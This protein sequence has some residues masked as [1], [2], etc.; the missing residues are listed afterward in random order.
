MGA[1]GP[2]PDV[3]VSSSCAVHQLSIVKHKFMQ[4]GEFNPVLPLDMNGIAKA[5]RLDRMFQ[6]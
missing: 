4:P 2:P 6:I 5:D 1:L 3:A